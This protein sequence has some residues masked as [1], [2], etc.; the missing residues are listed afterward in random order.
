VQVALQNMRN[1]AESISNEIIIGARKHCL[2]SIDVGPAAGPQQKEGEWKIAERAKRRR[3]R[4]Q[5]PVFPNGSSSREESLAQFDTI[6]EMKIKIEQQAQAL[7]SL[8]KENEEVG[9]FI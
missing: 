9:S 7:T 6:R 4:A 5:S 1:E 3:T 2:N 8:T